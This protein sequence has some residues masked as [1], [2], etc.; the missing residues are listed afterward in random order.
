MGSDHVENNHPIIT[1]TLELASSLAHQL[2]LDAL[3]GEMSQ[4]LAEMLSLLGIP[5]EPLVQIRSAHET[6]RDTERFLTVSINSQPCTFSSELMHRVYYYIADKNYNGTVTLMRILSLLREMSPE[7]VDAFVRLTCSEIIRRS[8]AVLLIVESVAAY[9]AELVNGSDGSSLPDTRRLQTLLAPVLNL[10]IS[11]ADRTVVAQVLQEGVNQEKPDAAI[12][13]DLIAALRPKVIEVQL[14]YA[15]LKQVT[16]DTSES[17]RGNFAMMRDGLFYELGLRY[18]TIH[19]VPTEN[20]KPDSFRFKIN[21]LTTLP[22]R[23]LRSDECLVNDE[24]DRLGLLRIQGR[25]T[26]NPA[27]LSTCSA[28]HVNDVDL[29]EEAGLTTWNQIGY[30]VLAMSSELRTHAAYF[31]DCD[32]VETYLGDLESAFPELVE[33]ARAHISPQLMTQ[34]LRLLLTEEISI[35]NLR[36]I[37]QS[38]IDLDHDGSKHTVF[39][40]HTATYRRPDDAWFSDPVNLASLVRTRMNRCIS[41]KYTRGQNTIVVYLLDSEIERLLT[42]GRMI[43]AQAYPVRLEPRDRD[44]ILA[45]VRAEI[46][47][48]P[49]TAQKPVVLT[50]S[51]ARPVFRDLIALEFPRVAVLCYHELSPDMNIQPIARI[52]L[53]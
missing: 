14:P 37:L 43:S 35:R 13:E 25:A 33:A 34:T 22:V 18:P 40:P 17:D 53:N 47:S 32:E 7:Q 6:A 39:D 28:I 9:R 10:C 21:H 45:A 19:F 50:T 1:L 41:Q 26:I 46:G 30:L 42:N 5:G 15:Y 3:Q 16:L 29:A 12:S 36:Q 24:P 27:N 23:G 48:L 8:P 20:L 44:R 31:L 11:I 51:S 49:A 38:M 52:L 2:D 4:D